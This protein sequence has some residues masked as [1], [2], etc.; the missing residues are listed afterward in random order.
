MYICFSIIT[1]TY[2]SSIKYK[3]AIDLNFFLSKTKKLW[4]GLNDILINEFQQKTACL[5]Q[6]FGLTNCQMWFV[7]SEKVLTC[8]SPISFW[9]PWIH[10]FVPVF[11]HISKTFC[12]QFWDNRD[13]KDTQNKNV[14]WT[15][16]YSFIIYPVFMTS[17]MFLI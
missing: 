14:T 10:K 5:L 9:I 2:F 8:K 17:D 6:S 4:R 16:V 12:K 13:N 11:V 15:F 1:I 7:S 3:F